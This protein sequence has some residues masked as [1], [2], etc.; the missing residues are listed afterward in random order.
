MARELDALLDLGGSLLGD[1]DGLRGLLLDA[2]DQVA[3]LTGGLGRTL[4]EL[5]DLVGDH[6]EAAAR[7][8]RARRLDGGVEGEQVGLLGDVVDHLDDR[9]DLARALVEHLD[10]VADP[11]HG[12]GDRP[13]AA[14]GLAHGRLAGVGRCGGLLC[15]LVGVRDVARHLLDACR[16]L[17]DGA[18]GLADCGGEL[19]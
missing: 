5:A 17:P 15:H 9:P 18:R 13:H 11:G 3:D 2:L 4:G 12:L 10:G 8:A 1:A 16:K 7:L 6:R 14:H 19:L